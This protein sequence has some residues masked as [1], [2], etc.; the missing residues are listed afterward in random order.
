MSLCLESVCCVDSLYICFSPPA[1]RRKRRLY[2]LSVAQQF[3]A[4]SFAVWGA[5]IEKRLAGKPC[6]GIILAT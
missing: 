5:K 6:D 3:L 4:E 1:V 2:A